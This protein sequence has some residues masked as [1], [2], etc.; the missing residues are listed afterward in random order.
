MFPSYVRA[1]N[2]ANGKMTYNTFNAS[3]HAFRRG[4]IRALVVAK[5]MDAMMANVASALK[6]VIS[7]RIATIRPLVGSLY[8]RI[9]QKGDE[10]GIL[11]FWR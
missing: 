10:A 7:A 2:E 3:C 4:W 5:P 9:I 6:K 11:W 8:G 1:L